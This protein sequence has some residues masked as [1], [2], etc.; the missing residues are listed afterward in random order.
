MRICEWVFHSDFKFMQKRKIRN[1]QMK[2]KYIPPEIGVILL[3]NS[4]ILN[5]S[6]VII[7]GSSLFND[8][9]N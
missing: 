8:E 9:E 4:D 1:N 6:D 7:D 3:A 2:N 5:G